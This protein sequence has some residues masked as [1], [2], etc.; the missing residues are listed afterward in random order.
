MSKINVVAIERQYCSGGSEIGK[1]TA[2]LLGVPCYDHELVT[3]AAERIGISA[4]DVE[5]YEESVINPLKASLSLHRN[6]QLDAFEKVFAAETKIIS[7]LVRK[8]PCV[9]VG[10]CAGYILKSVTPTLKVYICADFE[11]R[12]DRAANE[13]GIPYKEIPA[14]LK[15]YDK[16]R[17]DYFNINTRL[18]WDD[19]ETYDLC[20]NSSALGTEAC[21]KYIAAIVKASGEAE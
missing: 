15:R 7:E 21:A 17:G 9:I 6:D 16:K 5:K 20:L 11:S 18:E 13:H 10:R 19:M 12:A 8:G 2:E 1:R 4:E 14:R 3:M